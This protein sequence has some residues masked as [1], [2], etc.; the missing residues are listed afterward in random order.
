MKKNVASQAIGCQMTTIADGSDFT[1]AVVVWITGD[2]GSQAVGSVGSGACTHEGKGYHSYA[3][4]QAE[5]N[6]DH[7]A[8]TFVGTGAVT[9]TI[10]V[11]P[12]FPQTGD[13]FARLGAPAGASISADI[14][15]KATQA[16]V[17]TVDDFLDT[18]IA[19]IRNRLPAALVSGKM[20]SN[21]QAMG[22]NVMTAAAAN[23]DLATE[24]QSGLATSAAL[25]TLQTAANAIKAITDLITFRK[26]RVQTQVVGLATDDG[27]FTW[28]GSG[29]LGDEVGLTPDP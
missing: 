8:F 12:N 1:G 2:N 10:Q 7:I 13:N 17:D 29:V 14:A 16:S 15:A 24:L 6:Y 22:N 5:T 27:D 26:G 4:S 3:P 9:K 19:D 11:Y 20:D 21:V 28:T 18:E 25:A 23:A